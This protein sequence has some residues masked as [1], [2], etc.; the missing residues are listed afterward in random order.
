M[1]RVS[2]IVRSRNDIRFIERTLT[3]VL[4]QRFQDF[5]LLNV[6]SGSDDGTFEVIQ[7][8]NPNPE[9]V[10]RVPPD[11]YI[12][13]KILN[14]AVA[15]ATGE[16]MVFNNS[17]CV[18]LD[19]TWL[20]ALTRPLLDPANENVAGVFGNQF[21][22]PDADPL[23]VK[24]HIRAF[25]DGAEA[26]TWFHFFSLATSAI[27]KRFLIERPFD[28]TIRYS[29][30]I[31][32]SYNARQKGYQLIYAPDA[33]VEHSHNYPYSELKRRF[34]NEGYA[35]GQIY[36]TPSPFVKGFLVT[37]ARE[38]IRDLVF[39]ASRA[40][41]RSIPYGLIYRFRQRYN[42]YLGRRDYIA[43]KAN[44]YFSKASAS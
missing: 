30:D 25:S 42:A 13:G 37:W 27:P 1:P 33:R 23:V 38:T 15:R 19:D 14:Q 26:A 5:E 29:E 32:W 21:P 40:K 34:Y 3:S 39:L 43:G 9:N 31:E 35:E 22:R 12:P 16:I 7:R 4:S 20:E 10:W 44:P 18:P 8:L 17:D 24:D 28:E 36:G 2:V 41:F 6:D 11:A